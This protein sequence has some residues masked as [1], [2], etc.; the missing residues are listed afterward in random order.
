MNIIVTGASRGLGLAITRQLLAQ[1]DRVLAISRQ[2]SPELAALLAAHPET[3]FFRSCDLGA[4]DSVSPELLT[5]PG[6]ESWSIDGLVNNAAMAYDDLLTNLKSG[7]L[8]AMFRL[9]VFA[10]MML[11]KL[12]IRNMLLH[13]TRGSLV[14]VSSISAQTGFKGLAMYGATKGALESFSKNLAREWGSLGIRSNCVVPG[15]M[16]TEMSATLDAEQKE[17]IYRR[18]ALQQATEPASVAA[19]VC[20]LLGPGAASITGQAVVVDGG[21]L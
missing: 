17:K 15:F 2:E 9:N 5:P 18:A 21:T 16:E 12:A 6:G 10:A 4:V 19:T 8:E 1:G 13:K 20:F 7:E 14:H 11:S 3:L